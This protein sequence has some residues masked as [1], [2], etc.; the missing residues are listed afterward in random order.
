[1]LNFLLTPFVAV[2]HFGWLRL[3]GFISFRAAGASVTALVITFMVAPGIIE[4]LRRMKLHQIVREGTPQSHLEKAT[5]P[6]MGGL[7]IVLATL[8]STILWAR[9]DN[10]YVLLAM[11]SMLWMGVIGFWDDFLKLKQKQMGLKNTGLVERHKLIG[12]VILGLALGWF[13][14]KHP[15]S[16][17]PGASTT[18]PFYKYILII[19]LTASLGWLYVL[20]VTFV[21]VGTTN[22]VNMTDGVDGLAAGLTAIA[23]LTFAFFTYV[24]GRVDASTYLHIYYLKGSGELTVFCAAILGA[25]IGFLW[26]NTHPAQVFMGDTGSLALGGALAAIAIL[27][28]SE[29]LLLLVGGMFVAEM[30]SVILQRYVFKYRRKRY[31][32]E[33]AQTHRILRRAPLH[34]HF[35]EKGWDEALVVVR[36]WIL[37]ILFSFLALST[38]KIR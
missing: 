31:G 13:I 12:Q 21:M 2:S 8:F 26:Y 36:F 29:F 38:L 18:L 10:R 28:K 17:L 35:E 33:Y 6:T 25:C 23:A 24:I 11:F 37:G 5:T 30:M 19:P 3:F 9:L 4:R 27:I 32:L 15:L 7:I 22:A 16:T 1:M 20:F 14:W 34:H